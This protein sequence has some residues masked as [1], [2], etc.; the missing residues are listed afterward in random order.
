MAAAAA[1][2]ASTT[3]ADDGSADF[4]FF[5][6]EFQ[7]QLA[8]AISASDDRDDPESKQI[9]A[10]KRMSLGCSHAA[11]H[12]DETLVEFL[13]LRYWVSFIRYTFQF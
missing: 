4:N 1:A 3:T 5:E 10:A 11:P 6:E 7:V 8:L 13:S 2:V 12:D 9:K